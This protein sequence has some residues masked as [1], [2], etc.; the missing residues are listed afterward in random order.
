MVF[1]MKG[2]AGHFAT[3]FLIDF[4]RSTIVSPDPGGEAKLPPF[5]VEKFELLHFFTDTIFYPMMILTATI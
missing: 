5:E 2:N 3:T 4:D 1:S